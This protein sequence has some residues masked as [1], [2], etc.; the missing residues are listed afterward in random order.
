MYNVS[1]KK[2]FVSRDLVVEESSHYDWDRDTVVKKQGESTPIA[3]PNLQKSDASS[4]PNAGI[5]HNSDVDM[6]TDSPILKTRSLA[7]VYEQCNFAL[8]E[9]SSYEEAACQEVWISAMEE[10]LAMI[11]K[12]DTWE[13]IDR[14]EQKNVIGVKWVYRTKFNPDG[15]IFKHKARLVV[16]GYFQQPGVD[17]GDTFAPVA[18]HEI[19]RFLVALAAQCKWKI[20]HLDV[21]SAFLNGLLEEDI[22][23]EQPEGFTV[24]GEE[25]K[26]YK[27]KKALYGL[28]QAPRAWYSR[29]DTHLLSQG[30]NRSL[31]EPTLYFKR[32]ADGKL[33]VISVYVDDLMITGEDPLAVQEVKNEMLKVFE[34][35][36]L[37]EMKFFLGMEI[38]QSSEGIFLSQKKYAL[39]LLKKF[40][41]DKCKPVA[42][43]RVVNEK[44]MKD[45]SEEREDP[46][47][48]RS[49]IGSLLYL[50]ASRPDVM[51]AASLLSRYMQS[52]SIKHFGAAKRC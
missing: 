45:D 3:T 18:R 14:P 19:V 39:N 32:Q 1:S 25:D 30:F 13:L 51:F 43:P 48:Y 36:D 12:N 31:N 52:P 20:F 10:E 26:V 2:V 49:L 38:A 35:S 29:L 33:I 21:K 17:F 23:V 46:K 24:A 5:E 40:K 47:L 9:P 42:T 4:S 8:V 6:T 41:L 11:N 50:T 44:L 27:L 28:K 7:E 37:G 34:M 15:S 22:Y 16:K